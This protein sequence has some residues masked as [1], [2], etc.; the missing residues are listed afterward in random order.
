MPDGRTEGHHGTGTRAN[1]INMGDLASQ[2]NALDR[3]ESDGRLLP[4]RKGGRI[5]FVE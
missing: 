3:G 2:F 5:G 1:W 4:H